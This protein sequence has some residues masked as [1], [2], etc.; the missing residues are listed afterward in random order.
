MVETMEQ[1]AEAVFFMVF[2]FYVKGRMLYMKGLSTRQVV[3]SALFIALGL[4]FPSIFHLFGATAGKVF[5]PM[6]IPV[7]VCGFILGPVPGILCGCLTPLLSSIFT[8]MPVLFP[9]GVVMMLELATYGFF[10]G[11][12]SNRFG[13]Y[14]SLVGAMLCGRIVSGVAFS[15]IMGLSGSV[16][17]LEAFISAALITAL[18]GI[19]IQLVLVPLLVFSLQRIKVF[20]ERTVRLI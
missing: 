15:V 5:L 3:T 11:L 12:I 8:G 1:I 19:A 17:T 2:L 18:P 14:P 6:H 9:Q 13:I 10:T 20:G 4:L 16:Y 7:L